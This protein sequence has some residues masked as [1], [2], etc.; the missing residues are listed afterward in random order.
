MTP[1]WGH[2]AEVT[3]FVMERIGQTR[4]FGAC[5]TLAVVSGD[6]LAAG[7]VFFNW[8]PA[9]GVIEC[10]AAAD[11]PRWMTRTVLREALGY[12]FGPAACQALVARTDEGNGVVRKLWKGLGATEH[13][14]PRLRGRAASEAILLLTDDAWYASKFSGRGAAKCGDA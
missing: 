11:N 2:E 12:V 14:I 3:R 13:I 6:R 7:L 5:R 4:D 1:I 8:N 10:A 9:C